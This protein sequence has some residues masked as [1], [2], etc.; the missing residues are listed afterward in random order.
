MP[1]F[2]GEYRYSDAPNKVKRAPMPGPNVSTV[3][4]IRPVTEV[5]RAKALEVL[6][7]YDAMDVAEMLG[8]V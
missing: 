5:T 2:D 3:R 7:S 1:N 6:Q 4:L 8:L